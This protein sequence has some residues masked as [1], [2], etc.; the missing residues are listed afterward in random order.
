V[1]SCDITSRLMAAV[2]LVSGQ[3]TTGAFSASLHL[4]A[5]THLVA[6]TQIRWQEVGELTT[7]EAIVS[8]FAQRQARIAADGRLRWLPE[9]GI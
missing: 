2:P 5:A 4:V 3:V 1:E 8:L 9:H 7:L 6:G